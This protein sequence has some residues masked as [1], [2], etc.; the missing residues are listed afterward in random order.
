MKATSTAPKMPKS[1]KFIPLNPIHRIQLS[2]SLSANIGFILY[3]PKAWSSTPA[4]LD[5]IHIPKLTLVHLLLQRSADIAITPII[6]NALLKRVKLGL[7]FIKNY[8]VKT[9]DIALK[10]S[11]T[12]SQKEVQIH[13][14]E[15]SS[16]LDKVP[17]GL[18]PKLALKTPG[19]YPDC[20]GKITSNNGLPNRSFI[21]VNPCF[22]SKKDRIVS[23]IDTVGLRPAFNR[24]IG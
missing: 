14:N 6:L 11:Q 24:L 15:D 17:T 21:T 12:G 10:L 18:F 13:Q 4:N 22:L 9:A 3:P 16:R 1:Q 2:R 7:Y 5:S 23:G 20:L 8:I 19:M